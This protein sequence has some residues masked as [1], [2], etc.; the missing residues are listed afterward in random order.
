MMFRRGLKFIAFTSAFA[1]GVIT[2]LLL[3][4]TILIGLLAALVICCCH[5]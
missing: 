1:A 3:P 2:A 4:K 5:R